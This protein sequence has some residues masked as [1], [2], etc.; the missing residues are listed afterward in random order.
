MKNYK[1]L[2]AKF[3][4]IGKLNQI[5]EILSWDEQ[6]NMPV[7]SGAS[8]AK[9]IAETQLITNEIMLQAEIP[10]LISNAQNESLNEWELAN[11]KL[12]NRKYIEATAIPP[13]INHSWILAVMESKQKWRELRA[14]NDWNSFKPYFSDVINL[15]KLR[16]EA[17]AEKE[18]ISI[19]DALLKVAQDGIT[20]EQISSIFNDIK[21]WLPDL[22]KS[23]IEN[24]VKPISVEG[25]YP[26]A[27]QKALCLEIMEKIGFNFKEGRLDVSHHPFC[28]GVPSDVR[29]T[30][31]YSEGDFTKSL[32]ATIHETGHALYEQNLPRCWEF[33]PV[34]QHLGMSVHEGQSLLIEM[35]IGRSPEFL[36]FLSPYIKK[37]FGENERYNVNNLVRLYHHVKPGLIRVEADEVTYPAHVILRYE[38]EKDLM[39]GKISI[40]DI[41]ELWNLKMLAY[42]GIKTENNYKDGCLQD[43]HW[44]SGFFGYF[45]SYTV[46]SIIAAQLFSTLKSQI[47]NL[48]NNIE[49]CQLSE[50]KGWL[51]ANVW[52]K[53]SL[54]SPN[55]LLLNATGKE[56]NSTSY[57]S[58]LFNRYNK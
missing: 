48:Y 49:N 41:P 51:I 57:K 11:L 40:N 21:S 6:V 54:L 9:I 16:G 19:Y 30:T 5:S 50:V 36:T 25:N 13:D 42:L 26:I 56:L 33:Q 2:E 10:E 27:A 3:E 37:H 39:E 20:G 43:M 7:D 1:K 53:A 28:G 35:Q 15:S 47:D 17:L 38:I 55:Q 52:S 18:N 32:M 58:H 31:R 14:K 8:R 23:C 46:G 24:Q 12:I 34:G 4:R 29:I 22:I 44:P 45:P